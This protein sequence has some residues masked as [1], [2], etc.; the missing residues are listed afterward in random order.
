MDGRRG[1]GQICGGHSYTKESLDFIP[2]KP[3]D[4]GQEWRG[5]VWVEKGDSESNLYTLIL[6]PNLSAI[7]P[8]P[9]G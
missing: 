7:L 3:Q 5:Q 2:R 1:Q 9:S 8:S 4:A 6:P